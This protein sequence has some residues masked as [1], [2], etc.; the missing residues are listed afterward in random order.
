MEDCIFCKIAAGQIPST[1]VYETEALRVIADISPANLGHL[2]ILPKTHAA[3]FTE[4]EEETA[5]QVMSAARLVVRAMKKG[6]APD[7]INVVQN[8]G[9]AAGQTVRHYHM[10][11]IPRY[12]GDTVQVTWKQLELP[13]EEIQKAAQA[14]QKAL[15]E[16]E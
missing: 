9:E 10:H 5:L 11:I 3:D 7:G 1:T 8:N 6:I 13:M 16:R 4:L 2:L 12:T 15:E 14:V